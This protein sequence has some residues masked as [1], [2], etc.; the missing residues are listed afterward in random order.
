M[1]RVIS[2]QTTMALS[3]AAMTFGRMKSIVARSVG[4]GSFPESVKASGDY[5]L[6]AIQE[7]NARTRLSFLETAAA[8]IAVVA[9]TSAYDL[10]SDFRQI[11]SAR[12]EGT[13]DRPL[14]FVRRE[15]WD[16][17]RYSEEADLAGTPVFYDL[18]G[19]GA[20]GAITLHPQPSADTTLKLQYYRDIPD[21][22]NDDDIVDL[23]KV[24]LWVII[25]KATAL[26]LA[27]FDA[28]SASHNYFE[29]KA[30]DMF[31]RA[32]HDDQATPDE[33]PR[34]VPQEE[35]AVPQFNADHPYFYLEGR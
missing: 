13:E 17:V 18:F 22:T 10:P 3:G 30:E 34:F 20:T 32:K 9:G 19:S 29:A 31:R 27:T 6:A 14:R 1:S 16:R 2:L 8:D 23:P 24:W 11:L 33:N 21:P 25:F 7:V 4:R 5:V 12:I 35:W 15:L 28:G 26:F